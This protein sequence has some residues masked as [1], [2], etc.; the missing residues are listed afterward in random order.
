M[1]VPPK[2]NPPPEVLSVKSP[3][4]VSGVLAS[5]MLIAVLVVLIVPAALMVAGA[6]ATTPPV[7]VKVS[8]P[9]LPSIKLPVFKKVVALVTLVMLPNN[10]RW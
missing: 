7:N 3:V 1:I 4:R 8:V 6:V 2:V 9:E 5:P 10:S